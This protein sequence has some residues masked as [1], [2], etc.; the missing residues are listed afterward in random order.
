M[1]HISTHLIFRN[2]FLVDHTHCN[3][4]QH[5]ATH[6]NTLQ[7]TV[8]HSAP[9][10]NTLQQ[11]PLQQ[12]PSESQTLQHTATHCNTLQHTATHSAPQ[13]TT[14]HRSATVQHTATHLILRNNFLVNH[15][16]RRESNPLHNCK[17]VSKEPY[18]PSKE[19]YIH[20]KEP[21]TNRKRALYTLKRDRI[22]CTSAKVCQKS[23]VYTQKRTI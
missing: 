6:C 13:R 21:N 3:T 9:Q 18:I 19:P 5:T 14:A 2:N 22:R 23:P 16:P 12:L 20:S 11:N 7:H 1:H 17:G 15:R 8:H 4:L 10:R